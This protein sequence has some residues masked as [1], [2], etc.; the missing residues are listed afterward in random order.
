ML[1]FSVRSLTVLE[2]QNNSLSIG[3]HSGVQSYKF[4]RGTGKVNYYL[5]NLIKLWYANFEI[6]D[7]IDSRMKSEFIE[8]IPRAPKLTGDEDR[9]I[10]SLMNL[11]TQMSPKCKRIGY[12]LRDAAQRQS[13][14]WLML[15]A[16]RKL[17]RISRASYADTSQLMLRI[18]LAQQSQRSE[19]FWVEC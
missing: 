4:I 10:K 9:L 12:G 14:R 13:Q 2:L 1:T 6:E 19:T 11:V 5:C 8:S 17:L 15:L 7:V 3:S 16:T 18:L